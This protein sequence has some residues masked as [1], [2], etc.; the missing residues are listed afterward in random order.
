MNVVFI[1]DQGF[2]GCGTGTGQKGL[3]SFPG[4][5]GK[6]SRR[7]VGRRDYFPQIPC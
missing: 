6:D 4:V 1:T 3:I 5:W 7:P 2:V